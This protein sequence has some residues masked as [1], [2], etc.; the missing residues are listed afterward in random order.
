M[1]TKIMETLELLEEK[2][3]TIKWLLV[4]TT[5]HKINLPHTLNAIRK[6][7][8][9]LGAAYP[10]GAAMENR[11]RKEWRINESRRNN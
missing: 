11:L 1:S 7:A 8:G 2:I 5:S 9:I 6:S 4:E 3:E 10:R